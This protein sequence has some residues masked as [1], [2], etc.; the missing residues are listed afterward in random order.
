MRIKIKRMREGAKLPTYAHEGDV[1]MDLFAVEE[2]IIPA[3]E[4][5]IIWNGFALEFPTGF[6]AIVKDKSSTARAGLHVLGG[7]YDAGYRGEYN[8]QLVNLSDEAIT[9][10]KGQKVSQLIIMPVEIPELEEV[11][12]L[13]ET[14]RGEGRFGSTGKN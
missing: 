10:E 3:K 9:I 7:V 11:S 6:A 13:S 1:G 12:E 5:A 2:T 8:T 4:R 14:S